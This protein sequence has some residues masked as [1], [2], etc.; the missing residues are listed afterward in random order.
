MEMRGWHAADVTI[1]GIMADMYSS[2][3][4][5]NGFMARL[6]IIIFVSILLAGCSGGAVVF[7]PTPV[8]QDATPRPYAHPSGIFTLFVPP[9]W[10]IYEQNEPDLVSV[11]LAAPG[12]S[13]ALVKVSAIDV[14]TP[15]EP[16][17]LSDFMAQYQ[18]QIRRDFGAY[19]EVDRQVLNDGSWRVTGLRDVAGGM[20]RQVNTF[21]QS[22]GSLIVLTEA[23]LPQDA[24]VLDQLEQTI[25]SLTVHVDAASLQPADY[26]R[27]G[28]VSLLPVEI[29]SANTWTTPDG[30]LFIT[31]EVVNH[32]DE[33]LV[34]VPVRATLLGR[35]D[36]R[37]YEAIDLVM[38][39]AI[40]PGEFAPF[41][42]RFGEGQPP[43]AV[44]YRVTVGG[45]LPQG[46][47]WQPPE[48]T[49][50]IFGGDD[51]EWTD[52]IEYG[53]SNNLF[54]NGT[55]RNTTARPIYQP[56]AVVTI[57]DESGE[58]TGAAF[59]DANDAIL[60]P[61]ATTDYV[62]LVP[63]YGGSAVNYIVTVQGLPCDGR[64]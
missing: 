54:I 63:A 33:P 10:S 21:I 23:I 18:T 34:G 56:R 51:F 31:G 6:L 40:M 45:S 14:G 41:S 24:V 59:A 48:E 46:G 15:V 2:N 47:N 50:F 22:S 36:E 12:D 35:G 7:A 49:P 13:A 30:V 27:F 17:M 37:I 55:I 4:Q 28:N 62:V 53:Q 32:T 39:H 11:T 60:Q 5:R 42:L 44:S 26:N 38:G 25:N 52:Q 9:D 43:D 57:F 29:L 64:C 3:P 1:D 61:G 8:P 58:V 16:Q 19:N 20:P